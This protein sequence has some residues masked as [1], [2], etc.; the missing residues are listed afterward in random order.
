LRHRKKS[1]IRCLVYFIS[2]MVS[3][4]IVTGRNSVVRYPLQLMASGF[5]ENSIMASVFGASYT[6]TRKWSGSEAH[7]PT[8]LI[9]CFLVSWPIFAMRSIVVFF[10]S[11]CASDSFQANVQRSAERVHQNSPEATICRAGISDLRLSS[12]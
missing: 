3:S 1:E 9:P 7:S 11:H 5:I 8:T 10:A 12:A 4:I 6:T 2:F